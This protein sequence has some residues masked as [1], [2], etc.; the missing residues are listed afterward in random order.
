MANA[1]ANSNSILGGEKASKNIP[2]FD[3]GN[4]PKEYVA[5]RVKVCVEQLV[6]KGRYNPTRGVQ[7]FPEQHI[8]ICP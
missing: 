5:K 8:F 7:P 3:L 1:I 2:G 6:L 4:S